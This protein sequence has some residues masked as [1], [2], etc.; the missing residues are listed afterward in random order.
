MNWT[1]ET[2]PQRRKKAKEAR[3]GGEGPNCEDSLKYISHF[4]LA[5]LARAVA[6]QWSGTV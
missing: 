4:P 6:F 2:S 3:G 1:A 5:R